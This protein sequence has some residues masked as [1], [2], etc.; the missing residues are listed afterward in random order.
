[1]KSFSSE[2]R[3]PKWSALYTGNDGGVIENVKPS[4]DDDDDKKP[5]IPDDNSEKY[6]DPVIYGANLSISIETVIIAIFGA[7]AIFVWEWIFILKTLSKFI[8]YI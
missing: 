1:V 2:D 5:P 8:L 4:D 6:E 7:I 3:V